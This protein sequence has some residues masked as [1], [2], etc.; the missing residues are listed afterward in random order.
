MRDNCAPTLADRIF[1]EIFKYP[2]EEEL[3]GRERVFD[4]HPSSPSSGKP[5]HQNARSLNVPG[6]GER[7]GRRVRRESLHI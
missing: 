5:G 6:A 4:F 7:S 2:D 3:G 1:G